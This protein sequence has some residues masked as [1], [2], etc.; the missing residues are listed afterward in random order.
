V[1]LIASIWFFFSPWILQFGHAMNTAEID[2]AGA[3]IQAVG[4]AA[5]DAWV[6]GAIVFLISLS[7]IGRMDFWQERWNAV[8]GIWIFIAPWVLSF[9]G[10]PLPA[11]AWDHWITGAVVFVFA[12]HNLYQARHEQSAVV[13][14]AH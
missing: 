5:W 8:L 1:V 7:A 9:A 10:A 12:A 4:R 11:A 13:G 6:L 3:P 2:P 14:S